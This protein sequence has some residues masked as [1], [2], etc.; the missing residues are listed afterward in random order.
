EEVTTLSISLTG[1][2]MDVPMRLYD[3]VYDHN[4]PYAGDNT[5]L[6][7]IIAFVAALVITGT[8]LIIRYR[9]IGLAGFTAMIGMFGIINLFLTNFYGNPGKMQIT[10]ATYGAFMILLVFSAYLVIRDGEAVVRAMKSGTVQNKA[11]TDVY[12][13]SM[14]PTVI[15]YS[16]MAISGVFILDLFKR[17]SGYSSRIIQLIFSSFTNRRLAI[18][19][20]LGRFLLI[21]GIFGAIM[22]ILI[23]R[24]LL[25]SVL[26][27]NQFKTIPQPKRLEELKEYKIPAKG[28]TYIL[29][30]AAVI[31][32]GSFLLVTVG[33][34]NS[35]ENSGGYLLTARINPDYSYEE[36]SRKQIHNDILSHFPSGSYLEE[37]EFNNY[38]YEIWTVYSPT[39]ISLDIEDF[40]ESIEEV[41]E[42][43]L[44]EDS[45]FIY[46][47]QKSYSFNEVNIYLICF[48]VMLVLAFVIVLVTMGVKCAIISTLGMVVNSMFMLSA[49]VF[50]RI[51]ANSVIFTSTAVAAVSGFLLTINNLSDYNSTISK[52]RR[53]NRKRVAQ[54]LSNLNAVNSCIFSIVLT[55]IAVL[56]VAAGLVFKANTRWYIFSLLTYLSLLL[57]LYYSTFIL[58][59]IYIP[60]DK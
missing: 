51:P 46:D 31:I 13:N 25:R 42:G 37:G 35:M 28:M 50:L 15:S 54:Q 21:G 49:T 58:P 53:T 44:T 7:L 6:L 38:Y 11:V 48:A 16:A 22:M 5:Q 60:K 34:G 45:I 3:I 57:P 1:G 40:Y 32:A 23:Y 2:H 33:F 12:E 27:I 24:L 18:L 8:I 26:S 41:H 29:I 14:V 55:G 43:L 9:A 4:S 52:S 47:L 36:Y 10:T 39:K 17:A 59:G 56:F 19:D 30:A 20:N